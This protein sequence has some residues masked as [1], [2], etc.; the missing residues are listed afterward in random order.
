MGHLKLYDHVDMVFQQL[1]GGIFVMTKNRK[2]KRT[3][4]VYDAVDINN[5]KN[6][7]ISVEIIQ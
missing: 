2:G 6:H 4:Q 1:A 7:G 5:F 3:D